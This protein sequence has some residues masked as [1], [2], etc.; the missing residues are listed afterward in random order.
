MQPYQIILLIL[1]ILA[2]LLGVGYLFCH[3]LVSKLFDSAVGRISDEE[4]E[5]SMQRFDRDMIESSLSHRIP[6]IRE[7]K[8]WLHSFP[9]KEI[10]VTAHDGTDLVGTLFERPEND[11]AAASLPAYQKTLIMFHGYH[12]SAPH[13]FSCAC[14]FYYSLGFRL[15]LVDQRAHGRSGGQYLTFGAKEQLDVLTWCDFVNRQYGEQND[16]VITGISMGATTVLLAAARPE[17]PRNVIGVLADCGYAD[18]E[19]ELAHVVKKFMHLPPFPLMNVLAP[20]CRRRAHFDLKDCS[21]EKALANIR[22]PVFFLHGLADDFVPAEHTHRNTAACA[23]RHVEHL[24]EGAG[25]GMSYLVDPPYTQSL[26]QKF[27]ES[28]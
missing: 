8:Q 20:M 10:R 1:G 19:T 4:L 14:P 5:R 13:D 12:S 18:A 2:A 28:L 3:R 21:A 25:H 7:S 16:I 23:S 26:I 22:I 11:T 6:L 17:L 24:V 9:S 15:I 27:I